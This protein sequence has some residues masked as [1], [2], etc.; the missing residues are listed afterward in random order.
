MRLE[1]RVMS[2]I[3]MSTWCKKTLLSVVILMVRE[4]MEIPILFKVRNLSFQSGTSYAT[5]FD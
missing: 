3:K 2:K 5:L 1:R 4:V